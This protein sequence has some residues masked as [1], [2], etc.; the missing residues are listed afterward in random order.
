MNHHEHLMKFRLRQMEKETTH[1]FKKKNKL[2]NVMGN[3]FITI[4][5]GN[6]SNFI[7]NK[8]NND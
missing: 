1:T 7:K 5:A 8:I 2:I 3:F 6:K 4:I